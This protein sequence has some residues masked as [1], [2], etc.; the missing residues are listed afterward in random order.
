MSEKK[1]A[2]ALRDSIH[3]IR[4]IFSGGTVNYDG[5]VFKVKRISARFETRSDI[6]TYVASRSPKVLQVA[7]E[8]ADGAIVATYASEEPIRF[9]LENIRM[10]V[11]RAG[12]NMKDIDLVS[13]IYV[14]VSKNRQVAIENVKPMVIGALYY[15][16]LEAYAKIDIP[17]DVGKR[18]RM[19][20]DQALSDGDPFYQAKLKVAPYVTDEMVEKFARACLFLNSFFKCNKLSPV[21]LF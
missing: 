10:G 12:R 11:E 6:P 3:I 17:E 8:V 18:F 1:P 21:S 5:D 19:V 16:S 9:A 7:G 15:T 2:A 4:G 20:F 14:S 13:Y